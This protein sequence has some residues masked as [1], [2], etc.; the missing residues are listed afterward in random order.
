DVATVSLVTDT[1]ETRVGTVRRTDDGWTTAPSVSLAVA[2]RPGTNAVV[3]A[4]EIVHRLEAV[5]GGIVPADVAMTVTRNYGETANEK[6]NELLFH[7]GL[8]TVSIIV[9]VA[10]AIGWREAIVVA[11]VIPTTILLTLFAANVM[12]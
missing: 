3:I 9:L 4:E 2:K 11:V 10:V 1:A 7:L 8:A 6:A 5:R 12:G